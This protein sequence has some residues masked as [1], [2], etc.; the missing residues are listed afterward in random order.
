MSLATVPMGRL[1]TVKQAGQLT[2]R[3]GHVRRGLRRWLGRN[4]GGVSREGIVSG[5]VQQG[6][7]NALFMIVYLLKHDYFKGENNQILDY[8]LRN[9]I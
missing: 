6:P 8:L 3:W 5:T 7:R 2:S 9:K 1:V 4:S